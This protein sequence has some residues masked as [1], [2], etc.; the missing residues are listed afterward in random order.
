MNRHRAGSAVNASTLYG[1]E[2]AVHQFQDQPAMA[3]V[4]GLEDDWASWSPLSRLMS[5]RFR[6]YPLDLPWRSGGT[7]RWRSR[8][9]VGQLVEAGLDLVPEPV[10]VLVAHSL[11]ANAV[12][13]W[14]AGG[15]HPEI[16]ALVLLSPFYWPPSTVVDWAVFDGFREDFAAVMT[17]G[18]RTRLGP[19]AQTMDPDLFS[20]MARK[21]LEGMGPQAFL[22]LFD[23]YSSASGLSL[24][25]VTVPTLVIGNPTDPGLAGERAQALQKDLPGAELH[26][27]PH[28]THFC[29]VEQPTEVADLIHAFVDRCSPS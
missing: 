25:H 5:G 27:A 28:F 1:E 11:G 18:M 13:Q 20:A 19:R 16:D 2:L 21:M 9:T 17:A 3:F 12:L 23:Q 22:A 8:A 7:Y 4:H 26:L 10:S 29:H 14:L 15:V 24:D 6:S